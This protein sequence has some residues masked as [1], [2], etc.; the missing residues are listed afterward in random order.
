MKLALLLSCV[1]VISVHGSVPVAGPREAEDPPKTLNVFV[2]SAQVEERKKVDDATRNEL[3]AKRDTARD[4][5]QKLEKSLKEQYGKKR[6][7]WPP[8]KDDEL[9]RAEEAEALANVDYEY[10]KIDLKALKDSVKDLAESIDGKG[11]AGK[12]DGITLVNSASE[13]HLVVE[14]AGRRSEK[15][16]PTQFKPDR[17]YVLFNIGA[18]GKIDAPRFAKVPADFR[19]RRVSYPAWKVQSPTPE[20]PLFS[21]EA[22]NGGGNEFGCMSAASNAASVVVE[23]FVKDHYAV[24]A[25]Q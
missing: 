6:E 14:V 2:A 12:K 19:F 4:A 9:Y 1:A 3:K 8:E 25:S 20:R 21:F 11:L 18:G 23:Q 13:A 22:Y 16:L 24:L 15:T 7:T 17:C 10:R 5:R